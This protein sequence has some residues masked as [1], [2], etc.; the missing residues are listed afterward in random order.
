VFFFSYR[1]LNELRL[2]TLPRRVVA[3]QQSVAFVGPVGIFRL[4]RDDGGCQ[5]NRASADEW[6][7]N[8]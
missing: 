5:K 3:L 1:A 6:R 4:R 8:A 2:C 7:G